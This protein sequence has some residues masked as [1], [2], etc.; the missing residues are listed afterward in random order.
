[1]VRR[2][3]QSNPGLDGKPWV[4]CILG[5]NIYTLYIYYM[6]PFPLPLH[7]YVNRRIPTCAHTFSTQ[8]A[9]HPLTLFVFGRM[10]TASCV[11]TN[12]RD[13]NAEGSGGEKD[14]NSQL[15]RQKLMRPQC[16]R[17]WGR[18]GCKQPAV[19]TETEEISMLKGLRERRML[20]AS[21]LD[22][23]W[24]DLNAEGLEGEKDANSQLCGH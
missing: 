8:C 15:F 12:L 19:Y 22:I 6:L 16:W 13:F 4:Q 18:E 7:G 10:L 2:H 23:N 21:C 14:A 3:W 1:M 17:A 24:G 5:Q 20:T 9:D 11:D